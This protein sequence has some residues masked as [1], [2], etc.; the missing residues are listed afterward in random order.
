M[1]NTPVAHST[2][3]DPF[4]TSSI[5]RLAS[6][7]KLLRDFPN[8]KWI[9]RGQEKICDSLLPKAGRPEYFLGDRDGDLTRFDKWCHEAVAFSENLPKH[10]FENLALAQH[11]GLA[12]RLLDW[13]LN[14]AAAL[15]FATEKDASK[16]DGAVFC[17]RRN[18]EK[19]DEVNEESKIE[20]CKEVR[21]YQARPINHRVIAQDSIF[22]VH[23]EPSRCLTWEPLS[24]ESLLQQVEGKVLA[25]RLPA[26]KKQDIQEELRAIGIHRRSLF[27]DIEGLSGSINCV[28]R[29]H[30]RRR[31]KA[32][33]QPN[34]ESEND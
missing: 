3:A 32:K 15:Y 31:T 22:T 5:E 14:A 27:P 30:A 9:F 25:I 6:F 1:S 20:D 29:W 28:T 19:H 2:E 23:P 10:P 13:T 24:R 16:F 4:D 7:V 8:N 11:F 34:G 26:G 33:C 21:I 12:T 17:Y 18:P